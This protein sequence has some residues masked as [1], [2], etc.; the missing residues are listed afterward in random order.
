MRLDELMKFES[1]EAV[2]EYIKR[3]TEDLQK[4]NTLVTKP[5]LNYYKAKYQFHILCYLHN[6]NLGIDESIATIKQF[7]NYFGLDSSDVNS[8]KFYNRLV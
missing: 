5:S 8:D 3:F 7:M 6:K 1:Y 4:L 2:E